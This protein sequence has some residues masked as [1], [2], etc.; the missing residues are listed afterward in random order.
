MILQLRGRQRSEISIPM[1]TNN[2]QW[3]H[4]TLEGKNYVM[5][6]TVSSNGKNKKEEQ[7][8]MKIPKKFFASNLLLIGGLPSNVPKLHREVLTKKEDF[9]G[10]IRRFIVNGITQDL[11]KHFYNLGQ[12]FPRIE[13]G[14]YFSGDA[15]AE[16]SKSYSSFLDNKIQFL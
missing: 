2:G 6:L 14:S 3:H 12:C 13:K 10:C 15:Y 7:A 16:Y 1:K 11:T 5:T 9:K 4:V 8:R